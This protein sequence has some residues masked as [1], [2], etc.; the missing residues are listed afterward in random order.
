MAVSYNNQ[1]WL[2]TEEGFDQIQSVSFYANKAQK[3]DAL[4]HILL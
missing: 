1:F 4:V 3:A 2:G